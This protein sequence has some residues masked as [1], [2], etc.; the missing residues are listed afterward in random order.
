MHTEPV[1][2]LHIPKTGGT[3]LISFL[4]EQ[5]D[6]G[7]MCP[8]QTLQDLFALP[9]ESMASYKF[10][11]GHHWYGL[12]RYV[13]KDLT[14]ISM[15]RDPVQRTVS[16]YLHAQRHADTYRHQQMN[17]EGWSLLDFVRD[18]ETNWD[19]VNTQTLFLSAELDF[20]RLSR[21]PVGYGRA[22]VK[23]FAARRHDR[24]L[25]D[26]AKRR[27]ESFAFFGITER[28]QDSMS[29]LVHALGYFPQFSVP[30][31]NSASAQPTKY[32]LSA[33][34]LDAINELV[35]LDQELYA[36]GCQL[37]EDRMGELLRSLL[38]D[39]YERSETLV[40][41]SW[42]GPIAESARKQVTVTVLQSPTKVAVDERFSVD[43]RLTN[44]SCYQMSSRAPNQVHV[45]YHWLD[46]EGSRVVLFNGER[47][48]LHSP[49]MPHDACEIQAFVVAPSAAGRYVLRVTLVQ[50]GV[51]W[52]D[53]EASQV[54][55][56]VHI[57]VG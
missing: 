48:R 3:S 29:L 11:R 19:I 1:Y 21:D 24:A 39:R 18:A 5:F 49:L 38:N 7:E 47:T 4:E 35:P 9:R 26:V 34:E 43:V 51:A 17:E 23:E 6:T 15:L 8:A 28:M 44:P 22:A 12:H 30:K 41:K 42:H 25:L 16:W 57:T 31:L 14:H 37:F 56:D 54:F 20:E 45:S 53:D 10:F 2:F 36:W 13:G 40:K 27:L 32:E 52:F 55:G 33:E 50:E 46:E